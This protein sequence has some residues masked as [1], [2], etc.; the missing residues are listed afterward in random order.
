MRPYWSMMGCAQTSPT[1]KPLNQIPIER[2]LDSSS[3]PIMEDLPVVTITATPIPSHVKSALKKSASDGRQKTNGGSFVKR[4]APALNK[5]VN[6]DEQVLVKPRTPT[7]NKSWYE[8]ASS[9]M[10]M[11]K[12]PRNDD[13]AYD[14]DEEESPSDEE[15]QMDRI[16][17]LPKLGSPTPLLRRDL[18]D[19]SWYRNNPMD[20]IPPTNTS[21]TQR[22]FATLLT[23]SFLRYEFLWNRRSDQ[24]VSQ[25]Y[26]SPT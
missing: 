6:F 14:Y 5:T 17:Q 16:P 13:D 15:Q 12:H 23:A 2:I 1:V 3:Y 20:A 4:K 10:P 22:L 8:K 18:I 24:F 25:S 21:V 7:P 19:T 26:Q 11:R 9:T